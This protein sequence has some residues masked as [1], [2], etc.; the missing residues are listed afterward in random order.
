MRA[1]GSEAVLHRVR[2]RP[3]SWLAQLPLTLV[4]MVL[5]LLLVL[6]FRTQRVAEL[7]VQSRDWSYVVADLVDTNA[8]LRDETMALQEQIAA[9]T[10]DAGGG[11][12]LQS[13]VDE[14]NGLRIVNGLVEVSGPGI[15][16]TCSGPVSVLDMHDLVNELRNAG[17]EAVAINGQ[18][19]VGWSAI[20]TTAEWLTLDGLEVKPPYQVQ[21]IGHA[22]TL[23]GAATRRG[24]WLDL[25]RQAD[26]GLSISVDTEELL[27]LPVCG[28][29]V[30]AVYARAV[31]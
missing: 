2:S 18:R 4:C 31:E 7:R 26:K 23:A 22:P 20:N 21:A 30:R 10:A 3:R 17:A 29:K 16:L 28:S 12:V 19:V 5:G 24:G 6:Q 1:P 15:T 25:M 11:T 27:T 13:L 14:L 9:L 8:R